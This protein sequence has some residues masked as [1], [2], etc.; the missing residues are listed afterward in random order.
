MGWCCGC[1]T[2][3]VPGRYQLG[4]ADARVLTRLCAR[5]GM[6]RFTMDRFYR[7]FAEIGGGSDRLNLSDFLEFFDINYQSPFHRRTFQVLDV[8]GKGNINFMEFVMMVFAY[9]THSWRA[10]CRY[11]FGESCTHSCTHCTHP[12]H[13]TTANALHACTA[14]FPLPFHSLPTPFQLRPAGCI[15]RAAD[16]FDVVKDGQL[17]MPEVNKLVTVL[18]GE[19]VPCP[20]RPGA[21]SSRWTATAPGESRSRS[22][23]RTCASFRFW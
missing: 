15:A 6:D 10:L 3:I 4:I 19:A 11:A 16:I 7:N 2:R 8:N 13:A 18:Y 5:F 20:R 22:G 21:S 17:D 1:F 9:S 12:L 14:H 23:A